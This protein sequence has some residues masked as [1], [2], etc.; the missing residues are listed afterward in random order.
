MIMY[1]ISMTKS[2]NI[3][4]GMFNVKNN[5]GFAIKQYRGQDFW[6]LS[7]IDNFFK[8]KAEFIFRLNKQTKG[9]NGHLVKGISL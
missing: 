1:W 4:E 3:S 8:Q 2:Y 5:L 9:F 7:I 6:D